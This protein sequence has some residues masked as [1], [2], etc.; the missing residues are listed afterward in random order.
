MSLTTAACT[1]E[2]RSR[3]SAKRHGKMAHYALTPNGWTTDVGLSITRHT[4]GLS[5]EPL[6]QHR[7]APLPYG[8][9]SSYR[10]GSGKA[11][12]TPQEKHCLRRRCYCPPIRRVFSVPPEMEW[13]PEKTNTPTGHPT[14]QTSHHQV[15]CYWLHSQDNKY[16][17]TAFERWSKIPPFP[18]LIM[19]KLVASI[20]WCQQDFLLHD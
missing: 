12:P 5:L 7:L 17:K 10:S 4:A 14:I 20:M 8:L 18:L 6:S 11:S 13:A 9:F 1:T 16:I 3:G 19:D 15:T 2:S